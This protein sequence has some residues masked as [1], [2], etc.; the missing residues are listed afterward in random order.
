M[1]ARPCG[2]CTVIVDGAAVRS[3]ITP[4]S[5]V[6]KSNVITLEGLG[7]VERPHPLQQAFIDEQA[8]QCG[9][10]TSGMIMSAKALLDRTPEAT[11]RRSSALEGNLAGA[12]PICGRR[13][14]SSAW[15]RKEAPRMTNAI[16]RRQFV[17]G[18]GT[19]VVGFHA[20][21]NAEPALAQDPSVALSPSLERAPQLGAGFASVA[22]AR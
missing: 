12:A 6:G 5:S 9:Y 22:A 1:R 8:A 4:V 19:L 10:C 21:Q 13:K 18:T 17:A 3:C 7:T 16:S 14:R 11:C 20:L 15:L 2:A